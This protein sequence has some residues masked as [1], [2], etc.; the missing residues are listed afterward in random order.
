MVPYL[1]Q[2]NFNAVCFLPHLIEHMTSGLLPFRVIGEVQYA[3]NRTEDSWLLM[4]IN[5]RG[6]FKLPTEPTITDDRQ[7]QQVQVILDREPAQLTDWVDGQSLTADRLAN[8]WR[9]MMDIP[10]GQLRFVRIHD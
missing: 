9:V 10:P 8:G 7:S 1:L 4:L 5:N 3:A 2:D 6:V